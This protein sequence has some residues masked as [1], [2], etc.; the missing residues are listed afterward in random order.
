MELMHFECYIHVNAIMWRLVYRELLVV[1][2]DRKLNINPLQLN[3][4]YDNLWDVVEQLQQETSLD[5]LEP[6]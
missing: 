3:D 2:N 6:G 4:L 5:I 1:T